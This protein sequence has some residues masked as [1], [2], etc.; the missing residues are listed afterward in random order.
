[1]N[2]VQTFIPAP[3]C[4][5]CKIVTSQKELDDIPVD[6]EGYIIIEFGDSKTGPA[7]IL[8]SYTHAVI[9]VRRDHLLYIQSRGINII[10]AF[11]NSDIVAYNNSIVYAYGD[12]HVIA[13][14]NVQVIAYGNSKID[15]YCQSKV[16]AY[17]NSVIR[18]S[19]KSIIDAHD[20][21]ETFLY[22]NS[23]GNTYKGSTVH[24]CGNDV[25]LTRN[26]F[27]E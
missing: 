4:R 27:R 25:I 5:E 22:D 17:W 8:N 15:A 2:I 19:D 3:L 6:F 11:D 24:I 18:A 23:T 13:R 7:I 9:R 26:N 14:D 1:M 10:E 20:N 12:S 16:Y 21:S